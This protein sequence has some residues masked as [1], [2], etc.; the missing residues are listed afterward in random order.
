[1]DSLSGV[2][3]AEWLRFMRETRIDRAV[4]QAFAKIYPDPMRTM[5]QAERHG[6]VDFEIRKVREVYGSL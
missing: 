4:R 1:M 6:L 2:T 3:E 5:R